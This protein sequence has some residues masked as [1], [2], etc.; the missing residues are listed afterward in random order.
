MTIYIINVIYIYIVHLFLHSSFAIRVAT[1]QCLNYHVNQNW[2]HRQPSVRILRYDSID[3]IYV[4]WN[5]N[6]ALNDSESRILAWA[7]RTDE[8]S[9]ILAGLGGVQ[10]GETNLVSRRVRW[11]QRQNTKNSRTNKSRVE[12]DTARSL[13]TNRYFA[14]FDSV[15]YWQS[16]LSNSTGRHDTL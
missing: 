5:E 6:Q 14:S 9:L 12:T 1:T 8:E 3:R 2:S 15:L 13:S 4:A 10:I 16:I 11:Y 7:T